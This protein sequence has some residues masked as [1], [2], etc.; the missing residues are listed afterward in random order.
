MKKIVIAPDSFKGT[1]SSVEVAG[2]IK[3]AAIDAFPQAE[4]LT[5]PIADGGE[6]SLDAF[7]AFKGGRSVVCDIHDP[8]MRGI[9]GEYLI[10]DNGTAV[11]ETAA[12]VGLSL[13]GDEKD[14]MKTTTYG[15]GELIRSA[16]DNSVREIILALGGSSTNDGGIGMAA[17]LGVKCYDTG[18]KEYLPLG[19]TLKD[20][21]RLDFSCIDKRIKEVRFTAMCDV[22]ATITGKNGAT[23]VFSEQKGAKKTDMPVLEEGLINLT[24]KILEVTGEDYS[25]LA[26]G[27]AAGGMGMGAKAFL[28][29]GL[30]KGID[31]VLEL[32]NFENLIDGADLVI[33]GEGKLDRQSLMGK[34]IYGISQRTIKKGVRLYVV[35]GLN[36]LEESDLKSRGID[37]VFSTNPKKLPFD[38]IKHRAK[39]DLEKTARSIFA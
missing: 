13:A 25:L 9:K 28:N 38:E 27:G 1:M 37:K 6:G 4:I 11:I 15:V 22:E 32:A 31:T 2:I 26:G 10:T 34:V 17:A 19:G 23:Y 16:L 12:A 29:A 18:G 3:K 7:K 5:L 8:F 14:P 20:L 36:E 30:K 21:K 39:E 24:K 33:T 35:C